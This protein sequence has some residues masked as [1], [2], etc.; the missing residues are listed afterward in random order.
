MIA[1]LAALTAVVSFCQ[2]A[3][4]A[5]TQSANAISL[6]GDTYSFSFSRENGSLLSVNQ[7]G[8]T[9]SIWKSGEQ[10]L[11]NA[12]FRDNTEVNAAAFK[13]TGERTFRWSTADGGL[14][15]EYLAPE[16]NVT[17]TV[18]P[19]SGSADFR[20]EV[21]PR[22]KTILEFALPARL[23]FEPQ[24]VERFVSPM[25]GGTSVG[26]AFN[27]RFFEAQSQ[28]TPGGW[29]PK[30]FGTAGY[31]ALYGG[32]LDQRADND[33]PTQ[34]QVTDQ[35][36]QWLS[37]SLVQRLSTATPVVNRPPTR[38][39]AD[40]VLVDSANGPYYSASHLGG[41]G[42]LW[43]LGGAVR[44]ADAPN[45][46][47]MVVQTVDKLAASASAPRTKIGL[48][49]L[50]SGPE[51]GS[52]A[53]V[54][55]RDW[56]T[57][58]ASTRAVTSGRAEL[59]QITTARAMMEAL[60]SS[61]YLVILNPYG[62]WTPILPDAGMAETVA[63]VGKFVRAG[64][65]WFET[66]GYP[67]YYGMV[68]L[69]Y[70]SC[71]TNYPAAFADFF[72]LDSHNGSGS[73][74]RVQPQQWA[75]W[76]GAKNSEALFVPGRISCGGDELGGYCDRPFCTFVA[77]GQAWLT[78]VVRMSLGRTA[79][80]SL[81]EYAASN[82]INRRLEDKM[83]PEL[84]AKLKDSVLVYY[85]G[86]AADKV[87]YL[88]LL[89]KSTLV[90]F[91][92]YL[93]GGFDK[94]YPDHLPPNPGF[95]TSDDLRR[96]FDRCHELGLLVMPYTNPTWWCDHPRGPTF[97]RDGEDPLLRG[98]D[99]K[100]VYEK[101]SANDGWTVCHWHPAV[102][103]ANRLTVKQFTT[104]YPVDVLFQDQC[105]ARGW[106]Y[107][108]NPASPTPYAYTD[109]LLSMVAEDCKAVPLSTE[110]G[111]DRVVNYEAQLCGMTWSIVPTEGGP[112]WRRL[113]KTQYPPNT[114]EIFPVAQY[115]AHDKTQM[116]HHDLGQFVTNRQVL[117]WTLGL[118]YSLSWRTS[119][120]GLT[121]DASR[122]WL[123]WLDR[124]QKSVCAR[125]IGEPVVDFHHD[126]GP[127]P[128]VEDDGVI[129]ATYG[130]VKLAVN[131]GP[132]TR[133]ENGQSLPSYGFYATAPGMVA[134]NVTG[135]GQAGPEGTN[136]VAQQ[137][138]N[139]TDLWVYGPQ[140]S[141]MT[142]VLPDWTAQRAVVQLDGAAAQTV[143]C[144]KGALEIRT[145]RRDTAKRIEPP[146]ALAGKAPRDWPGAK[147]AV[148]VLDLGPAWNLSW[149]TI[150]PAQ[151]L[152]ALGKSPLAQELGVPIKPIRTVPDLLYALKTGATGWLAI[153]NPYGE[154]FP[155][156]GPGTWREML[157]LIRQYVENGGSWWETGGYSLHS[158]T[159]SEGAGVQTEAV[160]P[161]GAAFLG[162]P[163]GNG[164]VEAPAVRLHVPDEGRAWLGDALSV[165]VSQSTSVVNRGLPRT[166]Q[167]PGHVTLVAG[168]E[169]DFIGGYRLNGWGWLWRVGGFYPDPEVST[170]VTTAA[171]E[172]LY[173]HAPLPVKAGGIRYL[174]HATVQPAP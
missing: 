44:Q 109:G 116:L 171:L 137:G 95:G 146:A 127:E 115:I 113:M 155:V 77:A 96:L 14:K 94:E 108:T 92:D 47:D 142:V 73:V 1:Y 154:R 157:T 41:T 39:Q 174:W 164:D 42:Y 163:V 51:R 60:Q 141:Q 159:W 82:Q 32:R 132:V 3:G 158:A 85:A 80:E 43:R 2:P 130:D 13:P 72:H 97:L 167:D 87:K 35:G 173:T 105:G 169:D 134:A 139:V 10:G 63:A 89:P 129:R 88:D 4:A 6:T 93:K 8:K 16:I 117:A 46:L 29:A 126:R 160:G 78:P 70:L 106:R 76:E 147:P 52:W 172:Y 24:S 34:V 170:S 140:E 68:P 28:E 104:E 161:S 110:N 121:N 118:G 54:T 143:A 123:L 144:T 49:S 162:L 148:G 103:A 30:P 58:L 84:L 81:R 15:L 122:E 165:R 38:A 37:A 152:E 55:L 19:G 45:A 67:F 79:P 74:Y 128:T 69:R 64:G 86:N 66:G 65:N 138:K 71:G 131:L 145:P 56:A 153:V 125:Y 9:G 17:V 5:V 90:H 31:E 112:T 50:T 150:T 136:Y 120:A 53:E 98:L 75:P 33:P 23:R 135:A 91:A 59:E 119:A 11:W 22:E 101:Y 168:P 61:D 124:L 166:S 36:R 7:A 40:L 102:Q 12:R 100:P 83:S 62:E 25:A 114:W 111:W 156:T 107:D 57:R 48:L 27:S 26:S 151:W 133:E 99:G 149:T 20:A 21:Q 18:T